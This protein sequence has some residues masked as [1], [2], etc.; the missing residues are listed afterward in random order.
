MQNLRNRMVP[1]MDKLSISRKNS[2]RLGLLFHLVAGESRER[3][4]RTFLVIPPL[5]FEMH[6]TFGVKMHFISTI[7]LHDVRVAHIRLITELENLLKV[8]VLV[9]SRKRKAIFVQ[10]KPVTFPSLI[11]VM[12]CLNR[13]SMFTIII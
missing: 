13:K 11:S 9:I 4:H 12:K 10:S 2:R 6:M 8:Q 5:I 7:F 1:H 3:A